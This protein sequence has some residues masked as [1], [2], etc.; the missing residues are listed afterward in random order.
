MKHNINQHKYFLY[1]KQFDLQHPWSVQVVL[2]VHLHSIKDNIIMA[3]TNINLNLTAPDGRQRIII[4]V[5]LHYTLRQVISLA[6]EK[7][8]F[9]DSATTRYGLRHAG[10]R[11]S[12]SQLSDLALSVRLAG[13]LPG[14][15][16]E[17]I[18]IISSKCN[19]TTLTAKKV[20][21][22]LQVILNG[23]HFSRRFTREFPSTCSLW[24]ILCILHQKEKNGF[25]LF[26][27]AQGK[28]KKVPSLVILNQEYFGIEKL[29]KTSLAEI[30]II[31]GSCL[32]RM[33]LKEIMGDSL[34][35]TNEAMEMIQ[36]EVVEEEKT[37]LTTDCPNNDDINPIGTHELTFSE[38]SKASSDIFSTKQPI[39]ELP[40]YIFFAPPSP[41]DSHINS[42]FPPDSFYEMNEL[43][44][45]LYYS[46]LQSNTRSLTE[47]PLVSRAKLIEKKRNE[48]LTKYPKVC[49]FINN[50]I[51]PVPLALSLP[52][53]YTSYIDKDTI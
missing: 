7:F 12:S 16:L 13:L 47:A 11:I 31:K 40:N 53:I 41:N 14:S 52:F 34:I 20:S 6:C 19:D 3:N 50:H 37:I 45:R 2:I 4:S 26:E 22:G 44:G 23:Q 10:P 42:E 49:F 9:S 28:V 32:I 25:P 5:P 46:S 33:S 24:K 18:E 35:T 39:N 8:N 21:I 17:L 36:R 30:G 27:F 51:L 15:K 38:N 48:I 1:S 29:I 43:E